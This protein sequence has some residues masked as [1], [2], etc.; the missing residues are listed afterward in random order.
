MLMLRYALEWAVIHNER[1]A[2]LTVVL[3]LILPYTVGIRNYPEMGLIIYAP[4]W[5]FQMLEDWMA[6]APLIFTLPMFFYWISYVGA[7]YQLLRLVNGKYDS[8]KDFTRNVLILSA[9]GILLIIPWNLYPSA[10][11]QGR[12]YYTLYIPTPV[13]AILALVAGYFFRSEIVSDPWQKGE[14]EEIG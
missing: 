5:A 9:I 1:I 2:K 13:A 6:F 10:I 11:V 14:H 12:D 4:L 8:Y 3:A 7:A